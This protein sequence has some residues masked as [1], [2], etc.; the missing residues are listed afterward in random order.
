MKQINIL[1][2]KTLAMKRLFFILLFS[3]I[4]SLVYAQRTVTGTVTNED[5]FPLSGVIITEKGTANKSTSGSEG[6][7]SIT[8]SEENAILSA[9]L[10]GFRSQEIPTEGK[11]VVNITLFSTT[12]E[13][14]QQINE[15]V[16]T[17]LG[18]KKESRALTYNVQKV[19]GAEIVDGGQGNILNSLSGK[20]AGVDIKSSASGVGAESRVVLRGTTSITQNNN[21]LYVVDGIPMPNLSFAA[22]QASGFY[23]GRGA[24]F[25]GIAMLNPEDVENISVLTG[26]ASAAL[27][28]SSAA[29]GVILIT[30]KKGHSGKPRVSFSNTLSVMD[31]FILP[32]FQKTYGASTG[33][34]MYSWGDKLTAPST[35][36]PEDFFRTGANYTTTFG[37]SG[38]S[39]NNTFYVSGSRQDA[40][41]I[42]PNNTFNR[43]N[44]TASNSASLFNNKVALDLS[45]NY[46]RQNDQNMTTQGL[47]FNP[48]VPIYLMP[49]TTDIGKYKIYERYNPERNFETQYWD[50]G[51]LGM[52]LQNPYWTANRNI[53]TNKVNRYIIT[54]ALKV[55][56]ANGINITGR[57]NYDNAAMNSETKLYASTYGLFAGPL[58]AYTRNPQNNQQIYSD[59]IANMD[60]RFGKFGINANLGTAIIDNQYETYTIGGNLS[61]LANLFTL[62]NTVTTTPPAESKSHDQTQSVFASTTVDYDKLVYLDLTGRYDWPSRLYGSTKSFYFYPSVGI[63]AIVTD[64][65]KIKSDLLSYLKVRGSYSEVGNSP[66]AGTTV[67]T[68]PFVGSSIGTTGTR[69]S[70]TIQ[71]ERTRSSEVGINARFLRNKLELTATAY[72]SSTFNQLFRPTYSGTSLFSSIYVNAGQ[73]DNKGIEASLAWESPIFSR[74]LKWR[75]QATFSLNKNKVVS[76][77]RDYYDPYSGSTITLD[78]LNLGGTGSYRS[79]LTEG[80]TMGDI[81][82]NTLKKDFQGNVYVDA[83]SGQIEADPDNFIKAGT[84]L[85]KYRLGWRNEFKYKD[86]TFAFLINARVG[87]VGVSQTQSVMDFFGVS[88]SSALARENGG[89]LINDSKVD[90]QKFY[91]VVGSPQAGVG[92]YYVYS[93]TNVRLAEASLSYRLRTPWIKFINNVIINVS[94]RN[95]FMFYNKAPFDPENTASIGTYYQGIDYFMQPSLRSISCSLKLEF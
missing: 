55:N 86:F 74:E 29:N 75:S 31:P 26:A 27:Y 37:I 7:F 89:V 33:G 66:P 94:G 82:V 67:L 25:G 61:Q 4:G 56:I 41:G 40:E 62:K 32:R 71:P 70:N 51:D 45:F 18:I 24:A 85:A 14:A 23:N 28:G 76:L 54:G 9:S 64:I 83:N 95:L 1:T 57:L 34:S 42:I 17:A 11:T 19:S 3:L 47:Y 92:A 73:V 49:T 35:Y 10:K 52:A 43:Y 72:T 50:Y 2:K 20:I 59:I 80:G 78:K 69:P 81:Y 21:A 68:F 48:I 12:P 91:Q 36:N 88:E 44:F 93:M 16:I 79:I 6:K 39:E 30:T 65:F 60:R 58:G 87:G 22:P 84:S 8:I 5:N 53:F 13:K 38:G 77:L 63:S 46:I 90:A 15:V